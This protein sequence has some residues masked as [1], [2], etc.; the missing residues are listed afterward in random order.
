MSR[1]LLCV[2]ISLVPVV[3]GAEAEP[4]PWFKTSEWQTW[5]ESHPWAPHAKALLNGPFKEYVQEAVIRAN[6]HPGNLQHFSGSRPLAPSDP[7]L[8][9]QP[10]KPS[11]MKEMLPVL[12]LMM[13]LGGSP[14]SVMVMPLMLMMVMNGA[15]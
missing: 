7:S 3:L 11:D 12:L 13:M 8:P 14:T 10:A 15:V 1:F 6:V 5:A 9:A 2:A 4:V